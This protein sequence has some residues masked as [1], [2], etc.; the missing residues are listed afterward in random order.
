[1]NLLNLPLRILARQ[2]RWFARGAGILA[3]GIVFEFTRRHDLVQLPGMSEPYEIGPVDPYW[4][5]AV[6]YLAVTWFLK[7]I[8]R[9]FIREVG[10]HIGRVSRGDWFKP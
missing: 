9:A 2:G 10:T 7:K 6:S 3:A 1:M 8:L 5:S 4:M